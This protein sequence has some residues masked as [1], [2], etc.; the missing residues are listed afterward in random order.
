MGE[1]RLTD[2]K[3]T[4]AVQQFHQFRCQISLT[5]CKEYFT[6]SV[7]GLRDAKR[8]APGDLVR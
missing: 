7:G 8:C 5:T 3:H 6:I 2:R 1:S 4:K